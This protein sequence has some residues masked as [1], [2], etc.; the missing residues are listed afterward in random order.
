MKPYVILVLL[1]LFFLAGCDSSSIVSYSPDGDTELDTDSETDGDVDADQ[2]SDGD[3]EPDINLPDGDVETDIDD[4]VDGDTI[5]AD[6][7]QAPDG[8]FDADPDGDMETD[9]DD[10]LDLTEIDREP[11]PEPEIEPEPETQCVPDSICCDSDGNFLPATTGCDDNDPCSYT[12]EC[13]GIGVCAGT[14]YSCNDHG[15]CNGDDADC[16][17][18]TGYTGTFCH[19]CADGTLG[20]YPYC[21]LPNMN[22]CT[23]SQCFTVPPS[24]QESCY[25]NEAT[26]TCPGEAGSGTCGEVDYC[27][28]DETRESTRTV[29]S[30]QHMESSGAVAWKAVATTHTDTVSK[31]TTTS[32]ATTY[33]TI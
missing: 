4:V 28:Q 18:D 16:T 5:D 6:D 27:G 29:S 2:L 8:D 20:E 11:E 25:D 26:M 1:S 12:D 9:F 22:F 23:T 13:N 32:T 31:T 21:F 24:N 14:P 15:T 3:T 30:I 19:Q 7:E 33:A 17:C 10:D